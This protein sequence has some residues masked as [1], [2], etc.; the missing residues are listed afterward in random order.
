MKF[1]K[2]VSNIILLCALSWLFF[3]AAQK[4]YSQTHPPKLSDTLLVG[5]EYAYPPYSYENEKGKADGFSVAL[6]REA[7]NEMGFAVQ[8]KTGPWQELKNQLAHQKLDALPLVGRTPEREDLFDFTTP[9]LTMHGAIVVREDNKNIHSLSDL[10]GKAIAVLKGD[11]AE[12]FLRRNQFDKEINQRTTFK[13][14]LIE[15][16]EG[17]HDAVVIQRL[18]ALQLM[19]ENNLNNLKIVGDPQGIFK[20]SFCFAVTDGNDQ[21]QSLLNEGLAIINANGTFRKIHVKWFA[22]LE[23]TIKRK[24]PIVVGG[25]FNYPPYEFLDEAG[26]PAGYNVELMKAVADE[27]DVQIKFKL[28]P[29]DAIVEKLRAGRIDAIQGIL[30]SPE[31]DEHFDMTPAHSRI[32]YVIAARKDVKIPDNLMQLKGKEVVVQKQDFMHEY[33]L[34]QG[35]EE[36]LVTAVSQEEALRMLAEGKYDYALVSRVLAHY[37]FEKNRWQHLKTGKKTIHSADYCVGVQEGNTALMA[38]FTEG[39]EAIKAK[40][41]YREIYSKWLKVYEKPEFTLKE[42]LKYASFILVPLLLVLIISVAWFRMLKKRVNTRTKELQ[43][44]IKIREKAEHTLAESQ[45]KYKNL[46]NSIRDAIL[47]AD[48]ERNIIDCNPAFTD[49]FG[50]SL[51]EIKG[52][53]TITIYQ[54]EKE[55][56]KMGEALKNHKGAAKDFLYT[57]QFKKKDGTVFPG[58]VNVYYLEN[59]NG[60]VLGFIGLIRDI[61]ERFKAQEALKASKQKAEEYL[62]ISA[63]IIISLDTAGRIVLLNDSGYRLLG[64]KKGELIGKDWFSACIPEEEQ[65]K[66]RELFQDAMNG[67]T[68][69]VRRAENDIITKSGERKTILWHNNVLKEKDKKITGILSSG[70][71]ITERKKTERKLIVLTN[72]LQIKNEEIA[73]QNEEYEALNEELN[74][75]NEELEALN[76]ELKKS[77][78]KAEESDKLKSAFLANMSHEIR[79]PMNGILGFSNL[80]KEQSLTGEKRHQYIDLIT[81]SGER[82]MEIINNLLD[83]AK[84]ETGQIEFVN[85]KTSV[86]DLLDDLLTFL[87]PEAQKKGLSLHLYKALPQS[88]AIIITDSTKLN[89]MLINLINNAIKFTTEG[90]IEFGYK[91]VKDKLQFYVSDTGIGIT[92][93][94]QEKIFERFRQAELTVARKS[95]GA[96]LGLSI[97]RAF[98]RALGGDITLESAP[99]EGSTFYLTIPCKKEETPFQEEQGLSEESVPKIPAVMTILVAED[100][101]VSYMLIEEFLANSNIRMLHAKTGKEAMEIVNTD[102]EIDLVLM[103]IKMPEMDGYQATQII[104]KQFPHLPVIAQTAFASKNDREKA[105]S[106]GCDDYISK[107][108]GAETLWR[109]IN[110]YGK[111]SGSM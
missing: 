38:K 99:G 19:N 44:E 48:T 16:S 111:K 12:E 29:W 31:R 60:A 41:K 2:Q 46:Y 91:P 54:S 14:A 26:N 62:N 88:E 7:A 1:S 58:E 10:K 85:E 27:L 37:Y 53:N 59:P 109:I 18:L 84:I 57:A 67:A 75:N 79:T 61:T 55:F 8:F 74:E 92:E 47:V 17:Q 15:L 107:P 95:E 36:E 4:A 78:K 30:Y 81:K 45:K 100:D 21:L 28:G 20:Q 68:A 103:D 97:S 102:H 25:D 43:S 49:L 3:Q 23:T 6:F 51:D 73:A 87:E 71:D 96:G 108:L 56:L 35:L 110:Q 104:K 33:A 63:E 11:N 64:Y 32:S 50:Y 94:L 66:V 93:E 105:L 24:Q 77:K 89:Q 101:Y 83:I 40:G 52:K 72:E 106:A 90:K 86:N 98:A 70:E 5:C 13:T 34:Q 42:F 9:Y 80:L 39:L 65:K 69:S 76:A 22:P 82:M